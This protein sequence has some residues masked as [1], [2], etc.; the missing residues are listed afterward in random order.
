LLFQVSILETVVENDGMLQ[1]DEEEVV[2]DSD[3]SNN[4]T[5]NVITDDQLIKSWDAAF[6]NGTWE[7]FE[8]VSGLLLTA[9]KPVFR[10]VAFDLDDGENGAL[11][12]SL[13][14]G[15][16]VGKFQV[17]SKN[18]IVFIFSD[19][20]HLLFVILFEL[21]QAAY[22]VNDEECCEIL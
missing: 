10:M 12:F 1:N 7:T 16:G 5:D 2:D 14:A 4:N 9:G 21:T 6:E 18:Y 22:L 3:N 13:K 19:I 15:R 20:F 17:L 8:G 11:L